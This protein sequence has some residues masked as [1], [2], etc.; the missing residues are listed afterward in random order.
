[1][2]ASTSPALGK[3]RAKKCNYCEATTN[4]HQHHIMPV[5]LGG[6]NDGFNLLTV[7]KAHHHMLHGI[8]ERASH[9]NL[10]KIGLAN[11]QERG[12]VLG[13]RVNLKEAGRKGAAA[14][15]AKADGFASRIAGPIRLLRGTGMTYTAIADNLNQLGVPT[16]N[17]G[18]WRGDTVSK[19]LQRSLQVPQVYLH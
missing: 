12:I 3:K 14:V 9:S 16:A 6:T 13:N 10:T 7:C 18:A 2:T 11:A 17:K 5:L 19:V 4:L 8:H 1:M 15:K